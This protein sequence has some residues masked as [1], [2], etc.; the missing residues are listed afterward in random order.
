MCEREAKGDALSKRSHVLTLDQTELV[1]T[2]GYFEQFG[3]FAKCG[4]YSFVVKGSKSD[5]DANSRLKTKL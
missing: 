5:D 4:M 3:S 2:E 1:S